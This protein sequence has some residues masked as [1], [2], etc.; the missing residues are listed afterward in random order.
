MMLLYRSLWNFVVFWSNPE[1]NSLDLQLWAD[2]WVEIIHFCFDVRV[3]GRATYVE[4]NFLFKYLCL[5]SVANSRGHLTSCKF[6]HKKGPKVDP[7]LK[8]QVLP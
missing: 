4:F 6:C 2:I 7:F 1:E 5:S 8:E 3:T